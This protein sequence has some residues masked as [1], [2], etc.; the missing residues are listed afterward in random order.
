MV[1]STAL[2]GLDSLLAAESLAAACPLHVERKL[3]SEL[4]LHPHRKQSAARGCALID[5]QAGCVHSAANFLS[6]SC[7]RPTVCRRS[8]WSARS[9]GVVASG[10]AAVVPLRCDASLPSSSQFAP[11]AP[12]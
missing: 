11:L 7:L 2:Y 1:E 5:H 6:T 4:D 8:L 12:D 3:W 9:L 10:M